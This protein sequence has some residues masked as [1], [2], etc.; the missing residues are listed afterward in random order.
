M[1]VKLVN[2]NKEGLLFPGMTATV[3][4]FIEKKYEYV[5]LVHTRDTSIVNPTSETNSI[6]LKQVEVSRPTPIGNI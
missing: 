2:D 3:D 6:A 4:S 5:T 1:E